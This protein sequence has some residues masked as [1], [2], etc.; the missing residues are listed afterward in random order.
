MIKLSA[1]VFCLRLAASML[2]ILAVYGV[3]MLDRWL[4]V[5]NTP[6]QADAIVVLGGGGASRLRHGIQLYDQGLAKRLIL[7]DD[8][9]SAWTHITRH[10]CPDCQLQ[11]KAV[12]I[13][14]G[15]TSTFTDAQLIKA[16]CLAHALTSIIVVTDP[17]H[18]RRV[19]LT[20]H[21]YFNDKAVLVTVVS[22]GDYSGLLAPN[23][24]WWTDRQT[25]TTVI[26]EG[27]KS[28]FVV[29]QALVK[30]VL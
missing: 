5:D 21:A 13:V 10:L 4:V 6:H 2:I 7:V 9:T 1:A 22:S 20:F 14:N 16:F 17:Y 8:K 12:A 15:S 28:F 29:G 18:T 25:A 26:L 30:A 24:G 11:G 27:L 23:T 3:L 19:L